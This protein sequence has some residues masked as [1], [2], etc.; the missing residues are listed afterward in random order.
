[1]AYNPRSL[2]E[3]STS[4]RG[5]FRQYLP[6]TDATI[7]Q[8][9]LYV[10]AKVLALLA[11]EFELRFEWVYRQLF[12]STADDIGHM[13]MHAAD[14]RIYQK[15][16]AA[17]SGAIT[18]TGAAASTT[19]PAGIRYLTSGIS[20]VTTAPFTT[21]GAGA[22]T[23]AVQAEAT[24]ATTNREAGGTLTLADPSLYPTLPTTALVGPDGIGGGADIEGIESLRARTLARKANPPQGGA[25]PDY[26]RFALEVPGVL[27]AW[28]Y[29]FV[30][31]IGTIGVY[32]LF[33]GRPNLIPTSGDIAAV[34][35]SIEARRLIRVDDVI[36]IA[37][38]AEAVNVTISG[39]TNDRPEVRAAIEANIRAVFFDRVRPGIVSDPFI[40]SRSW[41]SE[42]IST[43]TGEDRHTLVTPT[44]DISF[45]GGH[46]PVLGTVTYA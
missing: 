21:D 17:S 19:Y 38:I 6:G 3:L 31:G 9:V 41:I 27:K 15:A 35:A 8:N 23:A 5:A 40:L 30:G 12:I 24:G 42:A 28:A 10:I 14:Y 1:M 33:Q 7:R 18:G 13:R 43:A 20:Y 25:L 39:L 26:E 32:V 4:I 46:I 37:P 11:R 34:Q 16:A 45:T 22:F 36:V 44:T 29:S 2:T